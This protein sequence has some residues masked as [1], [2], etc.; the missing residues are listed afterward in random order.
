MQDTLTAIMTAWVA[1]HPMAKLRKGNW[2]FMNM[3]NPASTEPDPLA[4]LSA[5]IANARTKADD[6]GLGMVAIFLDQ[7]FARCD[8]DARKLK[9]DPPR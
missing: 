3:A 7:A 2:L 4:E 5:L 6:L 8:E 1:N 9:C